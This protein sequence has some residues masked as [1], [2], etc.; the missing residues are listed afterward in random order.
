MESR[1]IFNNYFN[2]ASYFTGTRRFL[3]LYNVFLAVS[4]MQ[5]K[6]LQSTLDG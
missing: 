4:Q 5:H 3:T 6:S 2:V 1:E